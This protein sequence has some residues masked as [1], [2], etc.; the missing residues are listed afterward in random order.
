MEDKKIASVE[1]KLTNIKVPIWRQI[2]VPFYITLHQLHE[3]IQKAMGWNNAHLYYFKIAGINYDINDEDM[4]DLSNDIDSRETKLADIW[5][6]EKHCVYTYDFGDDWKHEVFFKKIIAAEDGVKYP[7]C[8][9]G[10]GKCP[11][12]DI[13]GN[14]GYEDLL[15]A[16]NNPH[17]PER[18]R[19]ADWLDWSEE[20]FS[21]FNPEYFDVEEVNQRINTLLI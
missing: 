6:K 17:S 9:K 12:E 10:A 18:Q 16:I 19:Y 11:P 14:A 20:D 4:L 15:K 13:G 1:V 5:D 2:E 3:I 8:F 7:R 21:N